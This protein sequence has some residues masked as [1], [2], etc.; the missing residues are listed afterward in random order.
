MRA[1]SEEAL[2]VEQ[3]EAPRRTVRPDVAV[4]RRPDAAEVEEGG[5]ATAIAPSAAP[6]ASRVQPIAVNLFDVPQFDRFVQIIDRTNGNRVVTV[7]EVLSPWNKFPG[8]LN[9]DYRRKLNDYLV[10]GVNIV[11]IDLLRSPRSE[12]PVAEHHI[13]AERR[14]AYYTAVSRVWGEADWEVYPMSLRQPLPGIPIPLRRQ[15][16]DVWLELQPLI[17]RVYTAG[18]HDDIDYSK[19]PVPPL[20]EEDAAWAATLVQRPGEVPASTE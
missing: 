10:G 3:E 12:L 9:A 7:I 14:A 11:E 5:V 15:D 6:P 16:G 17:D 1:R 13:P 4:V 18:G 19:P 8:R 20:S 2:L